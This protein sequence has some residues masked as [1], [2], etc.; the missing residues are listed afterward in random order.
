MNCH[1]TLLTRS[2]REMANKK[3]FTGGICFPRLAHLMIT[4]SVI[5]YGDADT[6]R[7]FWT[8]RKIDTEARSQLGNNTL[9]A[10]LLCKI[11][12]DELCYAFQPDSDLLKSAAWKYV[13]D[14]Q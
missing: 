12:M 4:L 2:R 11:S 8:R 5:G 10:L 14:H 1:S 13:K 7:V 9:R 3:T 6:E